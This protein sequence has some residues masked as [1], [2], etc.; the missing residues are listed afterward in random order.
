MYTIE[1]KNGIELRCFDLNEATDKALEL[2]DTGKE[3]IIKQDGKYFT[4][5]KYLHKPTGTNLNNRDL[6]NG[7]LTI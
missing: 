4:S 5:S 3:A 1:T 2:K 7:Y 6:T